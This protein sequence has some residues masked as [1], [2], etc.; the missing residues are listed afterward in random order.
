MKEGEEVFTD[1]PEFLDDE[2]DDFIAMFQQRLE[3]ESSSGIEKL[4]PNVSQDWLDSIKTQAR[5]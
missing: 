3:R 5:E 1:P 2:D 4:K